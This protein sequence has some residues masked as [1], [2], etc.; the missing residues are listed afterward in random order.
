[1]GKAREHKAGAMARARAGGALALA[2]ACGWAADRAG[3]PLGWMLGAM[4]ATGV[5]SLAGLAPKVPSFVRWA[6]LAVLGT[7]LGASFSPEVIGWL[8]RAG[9]SVVA[10]FA[11]V[12]A[13]AAVAVFAMTRVV[14]CSFFTAYT[15]CMPGGFSSMTAIAQEHGGDVELVSLVQLVRLVV[16]LCAISLVAAHFGIGR[17]GLVSA[18]DYG[19]AAGDLLLALA[20]CLVGLGAGMVLRLPVFCM[21][22]PM[23]AAAAL[24]VTEV[25][26]MELPDGPL[27]VAL[28][29]LGTAVGAHWNKF[30]SGK[31][32]AGL[33]FGLALAAFYLAASA[34][35]AWLV[36]RA[37]FLD[38]APT[39]LSFS[40][41]GVSEIS[42]IAVALDIEPALVGLHHVLRVL[43]IVLTL[44]LVLHV[45][46]GRISAAKPRAGGRRQP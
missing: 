35:A 14:R 9:L 28:V 6:V 21:V 32:L 30:R 39:L 40:P 13:E 31:L 12:A 25:S 10:M 5:L 29:L 2:F 38:L 15:A 17:E 4:L 22:C 3:V 41:G 34:A 20:V 23:L 27:A 45:A 24:E 18:G 44:P 26:A 1:M 36:S 37:I 46:A 16:V 19:L 11:T 33:S 42:L 8:P 7:Y 43:F